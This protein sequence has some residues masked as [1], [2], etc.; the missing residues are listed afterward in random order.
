MPAHL[1][2]DQ[3]RMAFRLQASGLS[4]RQIGREVGCTGMG[5]SVVL[6]DHQQVPAR[7]DRWAP[8]AW[9]LQLAEREEISLGLLAGES[10]SAIGRRIGRSTS[11]VRPEV[12]SNGDRSQYRAWRAHQRGLRSGAASEAAQAPPGSPPT[13]VVSSRTS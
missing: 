9:R 7:P 12:T 6:R 4:L 1:T 10:C 3:K 13:G 2:A 11:T 8:S 5:V